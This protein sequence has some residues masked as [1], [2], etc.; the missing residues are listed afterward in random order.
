MLHLNVLHYKEWNLKCFHYFQEMKSETNIPFTLFEKWKV[1]LFFV[2]LFSRNESEIEIPRDRD[3]EVKFQKQISRIL[4][5]RD[6][7]WLLG[8][9]VLLVAVFFI[10]SIFTSFRFLCPHI[11]SM[12]WI[13]EAVFPGRA[14]WNCSIGWEIMLLNEIFIPSSMKDK[15]ELH[16]KIQ[17]NKIQFPSIHGGQLIYLKKKANKERKRKC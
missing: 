5:K 9:D 11:W 16:K 17:L 2:S 12:T 8:C 13:F 6:F 1:K 15:S 14:Y 10:E 7:C 3:R 4:E